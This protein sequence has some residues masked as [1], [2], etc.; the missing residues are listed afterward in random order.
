VALL[1]LCEF[2]I[3]DITGFHS[4]PT[5]GSGVIEPKLIED[6]DRQVIDGSGRPSDARS[7]SFRPRSNE[8][9]VAP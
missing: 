5:T 9:S 8:F 1:Y 3:G 4:F 6:T 7:V 2:V